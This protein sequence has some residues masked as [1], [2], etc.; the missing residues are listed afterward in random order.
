MPAPMMAPMPQR[1]QMYRPQRA[2]EVVLSRFRRYRPDQPS[3]NPLIE[4]R[5]G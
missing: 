5:P 1:N 2:L 3:I 4:K